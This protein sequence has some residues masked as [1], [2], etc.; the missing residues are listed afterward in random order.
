MEKNEAALLPKA[1]VSKAK[2]GCAKPHKKK[3]RPKVNFTLDRAELAKMIGQIREE[4][5]AHS[6]RTAELKAELAKVTITTL[7]VLLEVQELRN[8]VESLRGGGQREDVPVGAPAATAE[9]RSQEAAEQREESSAAIPASDGRKKILVVDD[10]P[11]TVNIISHFLQKE[12]YR[13]STSL[14][15]VDGLKKA[16]KETP[17][18]ILLDIMMPDLNGFLFMSI[19]RKDQDHARIPVLMLSSLSEE[20][21]VLRG[22]EIGAAD[23]I[24]KP[25]SPQVLIAKVKK[26]L[27]NRL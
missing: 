11:T 27:D 4:T 21:D 24:T 6:G 16:F 26:S 7:Q 8:L 2:S 17:D 22:L 9:G 5:E 10:D 20:A 3:S 18:L 12:N 1:Q 14:S 25:F 13:V 15:G 23:Y 19:F